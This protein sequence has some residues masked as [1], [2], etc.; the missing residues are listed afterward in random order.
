MIPTW[1]VMVSWPNTCYLHTWNKISS[2]SSGAHFYC[3]FHSCDVVIHRI[4]SSHR[5]FWLPGGT[6]DTRSHGSISWIS[7]SFLFPRC[8]AK[9]LN[10][11]EH[12]KVLMFCNK[13]V[14][15]FVTFKNCTVFFWQI[16]CLNL[17]HR[18]II[19]IRDDIQYLSNIV[20]FRIVRNHWFVSGG[21]FQLII[22]LNIQN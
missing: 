5:D 13:F 18:L 9:R 8:I 21:Y 11:S 7:V 2:D 20:L 1:T 17:T 4:S 3:F 10:L 6:A 16:K 12:I 19:M 14:V 22:W 15:A